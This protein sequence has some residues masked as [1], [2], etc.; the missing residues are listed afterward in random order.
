MPRSVRVSG[1]S[2]RDP[3]SRRDRGPNRGDNSHDR[4]PSGHNIHRDVR[5]LRFRTRL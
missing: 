3:S 5:V 4:I 1:N 2:D